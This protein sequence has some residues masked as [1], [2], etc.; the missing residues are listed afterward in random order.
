MKFCKPHN[1]KSLCVITYNTASSKDIKEFCYTIEFT[2]IHLNSVST[3]VVWF[4]QLRH[5]LHVKALKRKYIWSDLN[6]II[7]EKMKILHF[8]DEDKSWWSSI[9]YHS[10]A[11][12]YLHTLV[13][14][15][16]ELVIVL[17][18]KPL[19]LWFLID[20]FCY[21]RRVLCLKWS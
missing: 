11:S 1:R 4:Y 13:L 18:C 2:Q 14:I 3:Y 20:F 7:D 5:R 8:D 17:S 21:L 9:L 15:L 19:F 10:V 6:F 12:C 16:P